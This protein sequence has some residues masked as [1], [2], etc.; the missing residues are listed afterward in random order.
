[1]CITPP[2][3]VLTYM[4]EMLREYHI[5]DMFYPQDHKVTLKS[6]Q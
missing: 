5:L 3:N 2:K 1:M 4:M 6:K